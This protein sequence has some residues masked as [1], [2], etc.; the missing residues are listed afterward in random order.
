MCRQ[1]TAGTYVRSHMYMLC[2]SHRCVGPSPSWKRIGSAWLATGKEI[3]G[4][5][6]P[7]FPPP[8][9][10]ISVDCCVQKP[11]ERNDDG[12]GGCVHRLLETQ[13][14]ELAEGGMPSP[15]PASAVLEFDSFIVGIGQDLDWLAFFLFFCFFGTLIANNAAAYRPNTPINKTFANGVPHCSSHMMIRFFF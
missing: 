15:N 4:Q 7:S 6:R 1:R 12:S 9:Q 14:V 5:K 13:G 11:E 2:T 10:M 8:S 3:H